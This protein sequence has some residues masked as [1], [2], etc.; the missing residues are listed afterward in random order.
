MCKGPEAPVVCLRNKWLQKESPWG[1]GEGGGKQV[2]SNEL[3]E[4]KNIY[5]S[6]YLQ[7]VW[8]PIK[9]SKLLSFQSLVLCLIHTWCSGNVCWINE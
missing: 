5:I 3:I 7:S 8:F 6:L 4:L 9:H 2:G 1:C